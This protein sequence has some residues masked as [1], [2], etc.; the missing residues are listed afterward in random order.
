MGTITKALNLLDHFSHERPEIRLSEFQRLADR[1]KATVYRHLSELV[2]NGYLEQDSN[3]KSYR[4]GP[5]IIRLANIRE[6]AFPARKVIHPI[7][8]QLSNDLGELIHANMLQGMAL[9]PICYA[10]QTRTG[11]RVSFDEALLL[12][13]HATASGYTVLSYGNDSLIESI[14]QTKLQKYTRQTVTDPVELSA[15]CRKTR[16]RGYSQSDGIM[17]AGVVSFAVPLFNEQQEAI[18][19][20]S[21]AIPSSRATSDNNKN[22]IAAL[23]KNAPVA[24]DRLGG[25]V[26]DKVLSLWQ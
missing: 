14:C 10:D 16:K 18:G 8:E 11:L 6:S 23:I 12:P 5:A 1:D 20:M 26:P 25:V 21:A 22:I 19:A 7:I 2:D 3:S 15:I 4:L 9:S 17:E 24:S 13:L